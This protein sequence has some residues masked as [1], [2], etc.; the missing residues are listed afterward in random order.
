MHPQTSQKTSSTGS[1]QA[2]N[3]QSGQFHPQDPR[4]PYGSGYSQ[5]TN[6]STRDNACG[7][8]ANGPALSHLFGGL[9]LQNSRPKLGAPKGTAPVAMNTNLDWSANN[10]T[11]YNSPFILVPNSTLF[12][13]LPQ[14]SSFAPNSVPGHTDQLGQFPY[15][16]TG[17]YP[18]IN[19]VV[20][21]TYPSWPYIVNYDLQDVNKQ[22][23][24]NTADGQK[25]P[26]S[27][28]TGNI[29]YLPTTFIPSLDGSA[30]STY[31]YGSVFPQLGSLSL[32]FQMMKT[33]NGYVVQDL[34][35]LTQQDPPIPRA[36]PAMWTNPSELTLAKCLENRE[37][38]TNVYIRG[39]LPET[40]DEML[41]AYAARFGKIERCKAIVDLDTGLCKGFGFVQYYN[42]E[43]CENCIRGFFYLGYQA[44]FAQK[45]RNSR[46]K[47]L[48]DRSSTN[49][50][51]TNIPIDWTEA[52][53]RRHFEPYRVVSEKISRDEKTGVSKEV[54]FARFETRDIAETVLGE[55]HNITKEDGVKLLLRFA[56]TKAQKML[57]QQSNE[58]RA[59]RAG[60]YNYSVEVVQ[61]STPSPSLQRFPQ[62]NSQITPN[63]QVSY[64]SPVGAGSNWTPATSI[65][66]TYPLA[67]KA[68]SSARQSSLSSRSLNALEHTPVYRARPFSMN[69]RSMTDISGASSKTA[70]PESPTLEPR[71]YMSSPRKENHKAGSV[72]PV[73]SRMEIIISTPRSCT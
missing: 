35:A 3:Y 41:N 38:I 24:W 29:Q 61:G 23:G 31:P 34:E 71:S 46:L 62:N 69:R 67:K 2:S 52:D 22:N 44:S 64:T 43:S 63:S 53:L 20:P 51:C 58:R 4:T 14:V 47:D 7:R 45:S 17:V 18:N 60:E 28:N 50:Y 72:S 11:S 16:S 30:M 9:N 33:T 5:A 8:E 73:S 55:F 37:G 59:Y 40:S 19:P 1:G 6:V 42:F 70:M 15:L 49:I 48:E 39:F 21:T 13:G 54:G 68:T 10:R 32:P 25:G 66:P 26:Q 27:E 12:N 57:K 65:S 56:D 36:V